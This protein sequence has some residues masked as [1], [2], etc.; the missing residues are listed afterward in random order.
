MKLI[1]LAVFCGVSL[2]AADPHGFAIWTP[3]QVKSMESKMAGK[4]TATQQLERFGNHY[5]MLA[6]REENGSAELHE[7]EADVFVI[8]SGGGTIVVG[9]EMVGGKKTAEH[10]MRGPSIRGGTEHKVAAGDIIHIPPKTPHQFL[11]PN[12]TEVT[13]FVIK[14]IE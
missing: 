10:E 14:V 2:F 11:V 3:S 13:Y 8:E 4:K 5:T 1:T 12:G 6:H 7:T 9:G